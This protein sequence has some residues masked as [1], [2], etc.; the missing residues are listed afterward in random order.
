M[1]NIPG[2]KI[3]QTYLKVMTM[4]GNSSHKTGIILI[5][6]K[7]SQISGKGVFSI[8]EITPEEKI[9]YF[10]GFEIEKETFYSLHLEGKLIEPTGSLRYL[11][12]SCNPNSFFRGRYLYAFRKI[13]AGEEITIDYCVTEQK[14]KNHFKCRCGSKICRDIV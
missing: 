10:D 4:N 12:H 9:A 11:N 5:E 2:L 7:K 8:K 6:E 14:I 3:I 13:P 1:E